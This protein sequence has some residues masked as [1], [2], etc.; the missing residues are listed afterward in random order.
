MALFE[1]RLVAVAL[2]V[3]VAAALQAPVIAA[4]KQRTRAVE[5]R[6][7]APTPGFF[8]F[9]D[10]DRP[11]ITVGCVQVMPEKGERF[12]HVQIADAS[13]TATQGYVN[14]DSNGDG[15][16]DVDGLFCGST[17]FPLKIVPK[18]P[19]TIYVLAHLSDCPDSV[20]TT[21]TMT[22]TFGSDYDAVAKAGASR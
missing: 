2:A 3:V 21:G 14:Q 1:R 19:I 16:S 11:E 7:T 5:L 8:A 13:G 10:A 4:G 12:I 22:A 9:C 18:V 15:S 17:E 6:Y 20:G